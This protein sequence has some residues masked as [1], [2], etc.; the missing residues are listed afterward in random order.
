M[1]N[2]DSPFL[3]KRLMSLDALRGFDIL[4][5]V[6]MSLILRALPNL[7]DHVVFSWLDN[8]SHHPDW[9]GFT[10]YDLIFPLFIFIVGVAMPFSFSSQMKN[11]DERGNLYTH[12]VFRTITLAIIGVVLWKEPGGTH[13]KYGFL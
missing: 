2:K 11:I 13:S 10:L 8:Q 12:I 7:S 4:F 5:L 3:K 6:G 9:H 1:N